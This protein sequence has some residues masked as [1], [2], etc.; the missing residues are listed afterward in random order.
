MQLKANTQSTESSYKQSHT[1]T[2]TYVSQL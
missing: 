2:Q 1:G